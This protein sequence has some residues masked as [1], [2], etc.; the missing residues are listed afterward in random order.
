MA[1]QNNQ[2]VREPKWLDAKE[3]DLSSLN[4]RELSGKSV[5]E[6]HMPSIRQPPQGPIHVHG[7]IQ[8]PKVNGMC[9]PP[10]VNQSTP[11]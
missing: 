8:N 5:S 11:A 9:L 6:L 2:V 10:P 4:V 3:P 7:A 1:E